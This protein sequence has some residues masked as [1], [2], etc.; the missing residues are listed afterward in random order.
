[1]RKDPSISIPIWIS[2]YHTIL[3]QHNVWP[4]SKLRG[5]LQVKPRFHRACKEIRATRKFVVYS[6]KERFPMAE[7]TEAIGIA[8]FIDLLS[9]HTW[10]LCSKAERWFITHNWILKKRALHLAS[11]LCGARCNVVWRQCI[12]MRTERKTWWF[13]RSFWEPVHQRFF[14]L[15]SESVKERSAGTI[16]LPSWQFLQR[17]SLYLHQVFLLS[18]IWKMI[19][20][21]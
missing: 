1:M 10:S 9:K 21:L 5:I 12:G 14:L 19:L 6:G 17:L 16:H 18:T 8:E 15:A 7:N 4:R 20:H 11:Y 13:Q 2:I 3:L